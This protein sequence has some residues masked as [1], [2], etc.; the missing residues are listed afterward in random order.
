MTYAISVLD[1]LFDTMPIFSNYL[2]IKKYFPTG[3]LLFYMTPSTLRL[4]RDGGCPFSCLDSL[5]SLFSDIGRGALLRIG[6]MIRPVC[7]VFW[8]RNKGTSLV[9]FMPEMGLAGLHFGACAGGGFHC[10]LLF[11]FD[12]VHD[13]GWGLSPYLDYISRWAWLPYHFTMCLTPGRQHIQP[14]H[15]IHTHVRYAQFFLFLFPAIFLPFFWHM[16]YTHVLLCVCMYIYTHITLIRI[17]TYLFFFS[18]TY[19][20]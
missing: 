8:C 16:Q 9:H 10:Q 5:L 1:I 11:S 3:P 20:F 14:I 2:Y 4:V 18:N 6:V 19:H 7:G 17:Y 15:W 13:V 12:V